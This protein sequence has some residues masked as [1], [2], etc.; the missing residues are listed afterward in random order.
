MHGPAQLALA[1]LLV[2]SASVAA[3]PLTGPAGEGSAASVAPVGDDRTAKPDLDRGTVAQPPVRQV[4]NSA[5]YL[6][7]PSGGPRTV[8][9]G[10]VA[11]DVGGALAG[12][13]GRMESRYA[14][15]KLREEFAAAGDNRTA[16]REVV[17]RATARLE[18]RVDAL[19]ERERAALAAY[20][21][22]DL[23][24]QA[25]LRE[26]AT[27]HVR[28]EA[29]ERTIAQLY[30]FDRASGMPVAPGTV[31]RL[32]AKLVPLTGPIRSRLASAMAGDRGPTRVY[33]ETSETGI[34]LSMVEE[35]PFDTEYTRVAYVGSAFDDQWSD[36][37]ISI[38][39]FERRLGELYPWVSE[40]KDSADSA[41][42]D[43]PNYLR[44]GIYAIAY[45]H[46]HGAISNRDLTVFYD[47]GTESVFY[48]VQRLDVSQLPTTE[49][50]NETEDG[51]RLQVRGTHGDGPLSV[52]VTDSATGE[53]VDATVSIDGEPVG[54]TEQAT[55][56]TVAP[57]DAFTVNATY[58]DRNVSTTVRTFT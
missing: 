48:E 6:A 34:V 22:G 19:A 30:T 51:L 26:L 17:G 31:A 3:A 55:L 14:T 13:T 39:E 49:V 57:A 25:Y 53:P 52:N 2:V 44:A 20:N 7:L 15:L 10:S 42:T 29:L 45:N 54:S 41:L 37:P 35:G 58:R 50:A 12:D 9:F 5:G 24:T 1:F 4:E 38:D 18:R 40:N 36:R 16:R 56:W 8:R 23:T 47:A 43:A 11:L 28:A 32:K 46:P 21:A 27:V 33:V